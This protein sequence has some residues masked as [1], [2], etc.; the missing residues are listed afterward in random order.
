[1]Y[2]HNIK[3]RVCKWNQKCS[4]T[5]FHA[6]MQYNKHGHDQ[7]A[8]LDCGHQGRTHSV[9][10]VTGVRATAGWDHPRLPLKH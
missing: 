1:M 3:C 4:N 7:Q 9:E 2:N 10:Q 5:Y 6:I 8:Y